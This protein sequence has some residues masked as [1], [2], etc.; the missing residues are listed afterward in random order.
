MSSISSISPDNL[1][2]LIAISTI[3]I[4]KGRNTDELNLIGSII[5]ALGSNITTIADQKTLNESCDDINN[6]EDI[7]NNKSDFKNSDTEFTNIQEQLT[8]LQKKIDCLENKIKN[9][10]SK[11]EWLDCGFFNLQ[12]Y[13]LFVVSI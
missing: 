7:Q 5:S 1:I 2:L 12:F 11:S 4:S 9:S 6:T 13:L 3:I 8:A 10:G